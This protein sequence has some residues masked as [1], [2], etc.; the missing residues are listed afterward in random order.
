MSIFHEHHI[1]PKHAGGTD[2]PENIVRVTTEQHAELHLAL[3]FQYGRWQDY[4]AAMG[5]AGLEG[6]ENTAGY[7]FRGRKHS[8]K[9]RK[10]MS[11]KSKN[12][13]RT[14]EWKRRIGDANRGRPGKI[15]E[16]QAIPVTIDGVSYPSQESAARALG[17]SRWWVNHTMKKQQTCIK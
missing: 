12:A 3:Y 7:G 6:W 17:R 16:C 8:D 15:N 10:L 1:V 2:D 9:A 14:P 13:V 11:E 5:L 4:R